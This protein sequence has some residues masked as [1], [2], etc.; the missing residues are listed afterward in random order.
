MKLSVAMSRVQQERDKGTGIDREM[1][2]ETGVSVVNT[3][4]KRPCP[5]GLS[6]DAKS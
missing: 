2:N 6:D 3:R 5:L 1:D 4:Q